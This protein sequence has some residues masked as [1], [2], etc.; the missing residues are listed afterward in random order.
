MKKYIKLG[1]L[2]CGT[3]L[4]AFGSHAKGKAAEKVKE[5]SLS[6]SSVNVTEGK[7]ITIKTSGKATVQVSV[8]PREAD[9]RFVVEAKDTGVVRVVKISDYFYKV[10]G[11]KAGKTK[12]TVKSAENTSVSKDFTLTVKKKGKKVAKKP[13]GIRK[14][15]S[16][17]FVKEIEEKNGRAVIMF[18]TTWCGYCKLLDPIYKEAAEK[19][20]N[21]RYYHVDGDQERYGLVELF[22]VEGFP[23]IYLV[24][25]KRT[26]DAGGY[27]RGWT[28]E[29]Y[30]K[31]ANE[32]K[33]Q[34]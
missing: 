3:F 9:R 19:D 25:N 1:V 13:A 30:I 7:S 31:W 15:T 23:T 18:G 20:G 4:L 32:K 2:L 29:D 17:N 14:L 16:D 6:K 11:L 27:Y 34:R 21:L 24:E 5:I 22:R 28:A 10:K 26:I 8:S 12:I 33:E